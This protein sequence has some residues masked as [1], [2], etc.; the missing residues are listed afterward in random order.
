MSSSL[1][2]NL[3][4]GDAFGFGREFAKMDFIGETKGVMEYVQNP[5]LPDQ[6]PGHYSDETQMT[7]AIMEA[8]VNKTPANAQA[9]L[10]ALWSAYHRDPRPGYSKGFG[11]LLKKTTSPQEFAAQILP[12]SSHCGCLARSCM[13]G[14][15]SDMEKA[16]DRAMW[17]ASLTHA[18]RSAMYASGAAAAAVWAMRN[19]IGRPNLPKFI[20]DLFPG[21]N[22]QTDVGCG[23]WVENDAMAVLKAAL[24]AV[25]RPT[26]D[27]GEVFGMTGVLTCSVESGGDVDSVAATAMAIASQVPDDELIKNLPDNL[28]LG[29]ENGPYGA[30]YLADLEEKFCQMVEAPL[31]DYGQLEPLRRE[32]LLKGK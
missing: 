27:S 31:P 6:I 28:F 14:L 32:A 20:D 21:F 23:K 10:G 8:I 22:L 7:L 24:Y 26:I 4:I 3:A 12:H 25:W 1:L 16:I 5:E 15:M 2:L 18:T 17:V 30:L 11:G 29:L 9:L 19:K 13:F